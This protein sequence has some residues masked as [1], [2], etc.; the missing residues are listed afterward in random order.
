MTFFLPIDGVSSMPIGGV[1]IFL[2]VFFNCLNCAPLKAWAHVSN[3]G[4]VAE[5]KTKKKVKM[6]FKRV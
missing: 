2:F 6:E 1:G 5:K 3:T 4:G